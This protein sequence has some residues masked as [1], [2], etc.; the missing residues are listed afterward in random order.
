MLKISYHI[1]KTVEMYSIDLKM[2]GCDVIIEVVIP[3]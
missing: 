1:L 3:I 2:A